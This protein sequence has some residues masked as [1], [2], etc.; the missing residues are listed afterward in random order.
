MTS[1]F[2]VAVLRLRPFPAATVSGMLSISP[3]SAQMTVF[4]PS[5]YAAESS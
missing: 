2:A 5:N 4:D 3:A 1:T